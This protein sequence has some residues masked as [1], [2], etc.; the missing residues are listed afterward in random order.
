M[1]LVTIVKRNKWI[2]HAYYYS[3]S[4]AVN[5][6]SHFVKTDNQLILFVSY[7]GRYFNDSPK[8]IYEAMLEDE[9]F[10]GYKLVWAFINPNSFD[11][12]TPKIKINSLTYIITA[13]KAR[14]WITNVSIERGLNFK[15]KRTFYFFT[16][17]T[18]LPKKTGF[19]N[20]A[21]PLSN[22]QFKFDCSCAQSE[23]EKVIHMSAYRLREEQI[24]VSG[25]PK[26]DILCNY[27]EERRLKIRKRLG[28]PQN[29]KVILYAPTFRDAY[30]GPMNCP[31]DFKKWES[32]LGSN[33]IVLFRAHPVV[34]NAT[35]IDSST[36]FLFDVSSYPDNVDL[37]I[38]SDIL[39]SDYSGIFFE[40]AVQKKP[41]FC[42][43]YDY[44]EYIKT[45]ELY[46]DI[47]QA[48]PGG[49]MTEDELLSAIKSE[50][51]QDFKSQWDKFRKDYV[52][53]F[54][55]STKM[56]IDKIYSNIL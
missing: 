7:G 50:T 16:T 36:G 26:N 10:K 23:K 44:N 35:T 42:Y 5:C 15:G 29:K 30:F 43:A 6:I 2:Y 34:A 18:S 22:F 56:C 33:F 13:L 1:S 45:R 20:Q 24:L 48:L 39:I 53:E 4:F 31:V 49:M 54:G 55:H 8:S 27:S 21:G 3:V 37:M 28:L 25:Y 40:Y 52:S 51:Y 46:F 14:C 12:S 32:A 11:I 38:A 47:R 17:H 19:D 41:M 9:R